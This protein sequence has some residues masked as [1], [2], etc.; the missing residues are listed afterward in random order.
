[1]LQAMTQGV[2]TALAELG[3]AARRCE[4][5]YAHFLVNA[6]TVIL[7]GRP[8]PEWFDTV[9]TVLSACEKAGIT[10]RVHWGGHMTIARFDQQHPVETAQQL[11]AYLDT[12]STKSIGRH[13]P[14][15]IDVV[16]HQF[17]PSAFHLKITRRFPL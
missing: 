2:E 11:L 5:T 9:Q 15:A 10:L 7:V 6:T 17:S 8:N 14:I 1:M 12:V 16:S 3:S 4:V 13:P